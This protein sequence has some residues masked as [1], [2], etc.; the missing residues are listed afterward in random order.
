MTTSFIIMSV[1]GVVFAILPLG[2]FGEIIAAAA[3]AG[4]KKPVVPNAPHINIDEELRNNVTANQSLLPGLRQLTLDADQ[5]S[6]DALLARMEKLM[7]GYAKLRNQVTGAISSQL[8]GQL[9][10]DVSDYIQRYT[11]ERAVAGGFGDSSF[12]TALTA[13]DL[14]RTSLDVIN[15]ALGAADRWIASNASRAPGFNFTSM[16]LSPTERIGVGQWN[17]QQRFMQQSAVNQIDAMPSPLQQAMMNTAKAWDS[18]TWEVASSAV[19][20]GMGGGAK[21]A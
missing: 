9:P 13:R 15:N 18:F 20:M 11:S 4:G 21:P 19:G 14:G 7:P 17:E 8:S 5:L 10:K 6:T 12:A 16:F 1:V 3:G 2:I